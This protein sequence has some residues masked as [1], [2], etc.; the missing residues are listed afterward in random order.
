MLQT[1]RLNYL[2]RKTHTAWG[3][4]RFTRSVC[5]TF[6]ILMSHG[7]IRTLVKMMVN[8]VVPMLKHPVIQN[9][10]HH[11]QHNQILTLNNWYET[12]IFWSVELVLTTV[13][14]WHNKTPLKWNFIW[15]NLR[16]LICAGKKQVLKKTPTL[17]IWK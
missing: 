7:D 1:L 17:H 3:E 9:H 16:S 12:I 6:R 11:G 15:A 10:I 2:I 4:V 8:Y 5:T 13:R 14:I